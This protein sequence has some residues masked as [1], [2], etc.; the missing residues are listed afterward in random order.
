MFAQEVEKERKNK[1]ERKKGKRDRKRTTFN[2][3]KRD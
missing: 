2:L 3:I 1:P